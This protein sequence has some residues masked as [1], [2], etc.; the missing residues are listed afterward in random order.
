MTRAG[1]N[2]SALFDPFIIG[3][4]FCYF[5]SFLLFLPWLAVRPVSVAVPAAG[6]T[7]AL[8]AVAGWVLRGETLTAMQITGIVAVG[9]G[10][11]MLAK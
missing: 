1:V 8:V 2:L 11:W 10:V 4:V 5:L 6:L 3:G 9:I 7:Y